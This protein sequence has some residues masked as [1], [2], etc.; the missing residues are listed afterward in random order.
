VVRVWLPLNDWSV[1]AIIETHFLYNKR[2]LKLAFGERTLLKDE[3]PNNPLI[4]SLSNFYCLTHCC[5][6]CSQPTLS[7]H[8]SSTLFGQF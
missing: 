5:Q 8:S 6:K 7:I 4:F 3:N 2:T 1:G